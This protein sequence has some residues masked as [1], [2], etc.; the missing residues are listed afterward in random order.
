MRSHRTAWLRVVFVFV[1]LPLHARAQEAVVSGTITDSSGAV[2]PGASVR[3]VHDATGNVF[4]S[5]TD[6]LGAYRLAVR[7]GIIRVAAELSGFNAQTRTVE[8]LVGQ[9]AV[10]NLQLSVSSVAETVTVTASASLIETTT[11]TVAG[12]VDP[13]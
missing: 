7:V 6:E 11:S 4:E 8:L 9:T 2:L 1:L 10:V 5:V 12:N 3:A 13:R